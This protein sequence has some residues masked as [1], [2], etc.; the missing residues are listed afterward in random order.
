MTDYTKDF[1]KFFNSKLGKVNAWE[2]WKSI[3]NA[4]ACAIANTVEQNP[5][6]YAKREEEYAICEKTLGKDTLVEAYSMI[7]NALDHNPEQDFL[8][9]LFMALGLGSNLGGQFFTPFRVSEAM[10]NTAVDDEFEQ[11]IKDKGWI[12]M[13]DPSCGAGSTLI[14]AISAMMHKHIDYQNHVLFIAND[15]DSVTAKMCYIQLSLLGCAG[16]VVVTDTLT[17]PV[18]GTALFPTEKE[19]QDYWY[20]P[21][22]WDDVWQGRRWCNYMDNM[23][24]RTN[25]KN[26]RIKE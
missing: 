14:G 13:N 17:N 6:R 20:T 2:A 23:I 8:G 12:A 3:I 16:Y 19:G 22:W 11:K 25:E 24:R 9:E 18:C 5:T 10:G 4:S 1:V 7:V 15:I 21:L 26:R